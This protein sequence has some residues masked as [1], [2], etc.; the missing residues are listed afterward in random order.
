MINHSAALN[1]RA[2]VVILTELHELRASLP[3][4][5][6][7]RVPDLRHIRNRYAFA[8]SWLGEQRKFRQ[9][10]AQL[11]KSLI[12]IDADIDEAATN[13]QWRPFNRAVIAL[14]LDLEELIELAGLRAAETGD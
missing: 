12:P 10:C 13:G 4:Y 7:W 2:S 11:N 9:R 8:L 14:Q 5:A 6:S 1:Q 3:M